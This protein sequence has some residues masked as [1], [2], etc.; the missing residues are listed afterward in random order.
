MK[1]NK[2]IFLF[3]ISL[4]FSC[5]NN[6]GNL[7]EI[8]QIDSPLAYGFSTQVITYASINYHKFSDFYESMIECSYYL[9]VH[10]VVLLKE[11]AS[12]LEPG[13][14]YSFIE[15]NDGENYI[16]HELMPILVDTKKTVLINFES[17]KVRNDFD[18]SNLNVTKYS[19][20]DEDSVVYYFYSNDF[21]CFKITTVVLSNIQ[22][23]YNLINFVK[24]HLIII[25]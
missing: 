3:V 19:F 24:S 4:V 14:S 1:K 8:K 16:I 20:L 13:P 15:Y 7:S 22:E 17:I 2:I 11:F 5:K 6:S 25:K 10:N 12:E 23:E 21:C 18:Y 9:N